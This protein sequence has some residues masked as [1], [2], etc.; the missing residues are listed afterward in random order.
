MFYCLR[1]NIFFQQRLILCTPSDVR[2]VG[3]LLPPGLVMTRGSRDTT[4]K[5][6]EHR[7]NVPGLAC[8]HH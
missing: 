4:R 7:E 2:G 8:G 1:A 3:K 6:P 5:F